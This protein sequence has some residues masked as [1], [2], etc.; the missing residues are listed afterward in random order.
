MD[1]AADTTL[2]AASLEDAWLR[3]YAHRFNHGEDLLQEARVTALTRPPEELSSARGWLGSVVRNLALGRHRADERRR[4]REEGYA[5]FQTPS[6]ETMEEQLARAELISMLGEELAQLDEPFKRTLL[7]YYFESVPTAALAEREGVSPGTIRW[8]LKVGRERLGERMKARLQGGAAALWLVGPG[9]VASTGGPSSS[10]SRSEDPMHT[11]TIT[12]VLPIVATLGLAAAITAHVARTPAEEDDADPSSPISWMQAPDAGDP[13]PLPLAP[14]EVPPPA[15]AT[16]EPPASPTKPGPEPSPD[17]DPTTLS[18]GLMNWQ[19]AQEHLRMGVVKRCH[20]EADGLPPEARW[21]N[22]DPDR[23]EWCHS[24]KDLADNFEK[25]ATPYYLG[26]KPQVKE[27]WREAARRGAPEGSL[28]FFIAAIRDD[29]LEEGG[30][31]EVVFLDDTTLRDA[32][33]MACVQGAILTQSLIGSELKH[34]WASMDMFSTTWAL[35][36]SYSNFIVRKGAGTPF[37]FPAHCEDG[38]VVEE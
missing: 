13:T 29:D 12:V 1:R 11:S 26:W 3:A 22:D 33:L 4:A 25:V 21:D 2:L 35:D 5:T 10:L 20:P 31:D 23:P 36:L 9:G 19:E 34:L 7:L 8:R 28:V 15:T 37:M 32:E 27:C 16:M 14:D 24:A 17:L 18:L 38:E 6:P 30:F